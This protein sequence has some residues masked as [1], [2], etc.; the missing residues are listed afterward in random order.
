MRRPCWHLVV[1]LLAGLCLAA[2]AQAKPPR[3]TLVLPRLGQATAKLDGPWE[4]HVGDDPR[5]AAPG[6]DDSGWERI[7]TERPWGAQGHFAEVGY[8]WYRRR[9]DTGSA[10]SSPVELALL[11]P[12]AEDAY[13]VYWN[14]REV[15][16][17]G[18]M[19]P[20]A[21]WPAYPAP[22]SFALGRERTGVLAIRVWKAPAVS[23]DSGFSGGLTGLPVV[24]SR[25]AIASLDAEGHYQALK[26]LQF[27][28]GLAL[29]YLLV[30]IVSLGVWLRR[31]EQP[32]LLWLGVFSLAS[33]LQFGWW[34]GVL[35]MSYAN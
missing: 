28:Y 18:R 33:V 11:V 12:F 17:V 1:M 3:D 22:H 30:A 7:T 21:S 34:H 23:F 31:R 19:P 35:G 26:H 16:R 10:G 24:G 32:L 2:G 13:Q 27:A 6:F 8:G 29:V 5:W 15:G 9:V 25:E 4:F 14:G 20:N